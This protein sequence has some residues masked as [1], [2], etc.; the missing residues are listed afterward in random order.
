[1]GNT[2][3]KFLPIYKLADC[4]PHG[5]AVHGERQ[6][7]HGAGQYIPAANL[8]N[9][10]NNA[11]FVLQ[12]KEDVAQDPLDADESSLRLPWSD[13]AIKTRGNY[14]AD[15]RYVAK[16][17][18]CPVSLFTHLCLI[19]SRM[20]GSNQYLEGLMNKLQVITKRA[21]T[22]KKGLANA[23]MSLQVG[24]LPEPSTC[25]DNHSRVQAY[26]SSSEAAIRYGAVVPDMQ[27]AQRANNF[28]VERR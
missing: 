3:S 10:S 27:L 14:L 5:G 24:D 13:I 4:E 23:R 26:K 25:A 20:N 19:R 18:F 12:E 8:D 28:E 16:T 22:I 11:A 9:D 6:A 17:G 7:G 21:P 2:A 15:I 1:M